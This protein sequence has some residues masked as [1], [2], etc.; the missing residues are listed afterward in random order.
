[1][2]HLRPSRN[3][4]LTVLVA[5][6]CC[7][8]ASQNLRADPPSPGHDADETNASDTNGENHP[9]AKPERSPA[10]IRLVR[11][12]QGK[13][14][15]LQTA[16]VRYVSNHSGQ[17]VQVDLI[18]AIHIGDKAYYQKLNK[19]FTTYDRLLYELV[20]EHGTQIPKGGGNPRSNPLSV[21]QSSAQTILGLSGQLEHIDYTVDN[22]VHADMSPSEMAEAMRERGDTPLSFF[23]TAFGEALREQSRQLEDDE[24]EDG[25]A[26]ADPF[27]EI[28]LLSLMT[29][30][31]AGSKLKLAMAVQFANEG[32]LDR[33]FGATLNQAI[34][35]DRNKAAMKVLN[36]QI[37]KGHRKLG[38]FYGAAHLAD[39]EKRLINELG[40]QRT[41]TTW[42]TAWDLTE[43]ATPKATRSPLDQL[44][45]MLSQ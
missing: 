26:T 25:E 11:D 36:E 42:I 16:S 32:A 39:F 9:E 17:R 44:F 10:F 22:F 21:M 2:L 15:A 5:I 41:Q 29:D 23:L 40:M 18:G 30:A 37:A 3:P 35:V 19:Q 14:R 33:T 28:N 6:G 34:V 8:F 31:N 12:E 38:I 20:A 43:A 13:A 1:M 45:R 4:L 24:K 7:F 27:A